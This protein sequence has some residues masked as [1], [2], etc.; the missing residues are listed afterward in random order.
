MDVPSVISAICA[1]LTLGVVIFSV[2]YGALKYIDD[3]RNREIKKREEEMAAFEKIVSGLSSAVFAEQLSSA[4][5]L[6]RYYASPFADLKKEATNVIS[7]LLRTFPTGVLQKT[8]GDGLAFADTL[9]YA[10][11]QNTN[12]QNVYLGVKKGKTLNLQKADFYLADLSYAL[13]DH[14][15]AQGAYFKNS[16]LMRTR[17]KNSDLTGACFSNCNL[18]QVSFLNVIL[19][20]A[21]FSGSADIPQEI[22]AQLDARGHFTSD[23]KVNVEAKLSGVRIFFSMPSC[24]SRSDDLLVKEY[25]SVLEKKGH[26]VIVYSRDDYPNFGQFN[27][28]RNSI[29]LSHA[30]VTF[31][32]KQTC[33][34]EG[35]FRPG[36]PQERKLK[37]EWLPTDWNNVETGMGIMKGLPILLVHDKSVNN[38]IFDAKLSEVFV[39]SILTETDVSKIESHPAFIKWLAVLEKPTNPPAQGQPKQ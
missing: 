28:I 34:S 24:M 10:D 2:T 1:A 38:G 23:S 8:L 4:V 37:D 22:A 29:H 33:V 30:M 5:L 25:K 13:L 17:I 39:A 20:D 32:F 16:S 36:T 3:K 12:L 11:L 7:S 14:V 26:E 15:N 18:S 6:R 27:K 31:G 21:D 9:E 35:V 19:K